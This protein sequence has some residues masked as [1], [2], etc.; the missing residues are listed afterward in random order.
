MPCA[1][2]TSLAHYANGTL[3]A[4]PAEVRR[5]LAGCIKCGEKLRELLIDSRT[6]TPSQPPT[7]DVSIRAADRKLPGL[8]VHGDQ[9]GRYVILEPLAAGGMGEVYSA[10]DPQLDRRVALKILRPD[11]LRGLGAAEGRTR[12]LREAQAMARLNHANVITVH[13][14]GAVGEQMFIAMEFIDGITLRDWLEEP[15]RDWRQIVDVRARTCSRRRSP[16]P[17]PSWARRGTCRPSSST[18][19]PPTR[20]PINS[21]W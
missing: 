10:Y 9:V 12:L 8:F 1:D 14:V 16:R 6:V 20:A 4:E 11:I 5:H 15:G 18:A 7:I 2:E 17:A 3:A 19:S 13:D 21:R